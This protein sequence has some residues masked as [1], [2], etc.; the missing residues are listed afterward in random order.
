MLPAFDPAVAPR[1]VLL[2]RGPGNPIFTYRKSTFPYRKFPLKS[3]FFRYESP[4]FCTVFSPTPVQTAKNPR[5]IAAGANWLG[6]THTRLCMSQTCVLQL[7]GAA[8]RPSDGRGRLVPPPS[9]VGFPP[10]FLAE[11]RSLACW[12]PRTPTATPVFPPHLL[13]NHSRP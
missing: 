3:S 2:S 4:V 13:P 1:A 5:K 7:I 9:H 12:S 11:N 10:F 8:H 6:N